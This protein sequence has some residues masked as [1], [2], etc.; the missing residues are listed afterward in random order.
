MSEI[1]KFDWKSQLEKDLNVYEFE[2]TLPGSK[3]TVRFKP[4]TTKLLKKLLVY[5]NTTDQEIAENALDD[6]IV[7]SVI[8][9]SDF[10]IDDLFLQ[11]RFSLLFEIR[12][13]SKGESYEFDFKCDKCQGQV[14]QV[15]DLNSFKEIQLPAK[16]EK[17]IKIS[18]SLTVEVDFITRAQQKEVYSFV[19]KIENSLVHKN[20]K[21]G[22]LSLGVLARSIRAVKSGKDKDEN[23]SL[24]DAVYLLDS[25]PESKLE[26]FKKW[27]EVNHF[28]PVM[29]F[30]KR[31]FH[32]G[33]EEEIDVPLTEFF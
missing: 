24:E 3:Q 33:H 32:C 20:Q 5:D 22:E 19:K 13:K 10:K 2:K 4:I 17:D 26:D 15:V 11:D 25:L 16:Y 9:P 1:K 21:L 23:I 29:K 14:K 31:C 8:S 27:F 28:G 6:I 30:T 12:K 7:N 18:D